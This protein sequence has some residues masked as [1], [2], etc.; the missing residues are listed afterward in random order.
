[1]DQNYTKITD[2]IV[3]E[4]KAIAGEGNVIY[5]DPEKLEDYRGDTFVALMPDAEG[6]EVAVRPETTEQVSNIMK[7]ASEKMI[8][9]TPR[10]A[11]SGLAGGAIPTDGGIVLSLDKMNK[12][13]EVNI[14]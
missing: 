2:E 13:L 3:A 12:I 6:P 1:M 14:F 4:L 5:D 9:V 10:G 11:G 8:P 7:L